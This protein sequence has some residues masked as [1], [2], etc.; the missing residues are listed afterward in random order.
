MNI[1]F[2]HI[3]DIFFV[4]FHTALIVFNLF[5]WIWR[6]TRRLNFIT[7]LLT[8]ASWGVLGIFWGW[9]YCPLTDWHFEVLHHLDVYDLPNSYIL[10]LY[11]RLTGAVADA[12]LVD[13]LTFTGYLLA[14]ILS[15]FFNFFSKK[16]LSFHKN[17][18]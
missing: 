11:R 5:G 4:V 2:W 8:G 14:L 18:V 13:I 1:A 12:Y 15:V 3:A 10:Y 7:L 9:G 16:I 17:C 6:K